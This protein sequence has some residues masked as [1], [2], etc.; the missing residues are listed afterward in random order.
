MLMKFLGK[1]E[2]FHEFAIQPKEGKYS[3]VVMDQSGV[4]VRKEIGEIDEVQKQNNLAPP[5]N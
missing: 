3:I 2:K 5:Q 1:T 4:E